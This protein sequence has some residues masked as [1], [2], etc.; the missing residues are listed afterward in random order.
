MKIIDTVRKK[1]IERKGSKP[2]KEKEGES[3]RER[4]RES[5]RE[6]ES[7]KVVAQT[8]TFIPFSARSSHYKKK[9]TPFFPRLSVVG[10]IFFGPKRTKNK[11]PPLFKSGSTVCENRKRI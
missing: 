4:K 3:A 11:G 1:H 10:R 5:E 6:R 8:A 7:D 2:D 9:E